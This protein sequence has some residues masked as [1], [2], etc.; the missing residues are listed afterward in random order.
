MKPKNWARVNH[1]PPMHQ[2]AILSMGWAAFF[3][4]PQ[5]INFFLFF[6]NEFFLGCFFLNPDPH[7]TFPP[8]Y[9]TDLATLLTYILTLLIN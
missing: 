9:P 8:N 6:T 3:V 5:S 4:Q 7:T 1:H 2:L